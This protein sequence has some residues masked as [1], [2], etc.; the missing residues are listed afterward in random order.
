MEIVRRGENTYLAHP[1]TEDM[2][3][4]LRLAKNSEAHHGLWTKAPGDEAEFLNY[5]NKYQ[6]ANQASFLV[7]LNNSNDIAGVININEIIRGSFQNGFLGYYSFKGYQGK[8]YMTEGVRLVCLHAFH[9]LGLHRL[10][11][12]IQ[13]ENKRSIALI[14]R[15]KFREEGLAKNYLKINGK[16]QDHLRF[17]IVAEELS[18]N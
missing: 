4:F 17:A 1:R 8:G 11:A 9:E 3:E 18:G 13:P 16:W 15:C 12:N 10:E 7:R 2:D 14:K 6:Q 5:L